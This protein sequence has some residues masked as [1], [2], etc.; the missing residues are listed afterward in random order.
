MQAIKHNCYNL[1]L[2]LLSAGAVACDQIDLGKLIASTSLPSNPELFQQLLE[3]GISPNGIS[4]SGTSNDTTTPLDAV[5]RLI[6]YPTERKVPLICTL[7]E[8]GANLEYISTPTQE[9]TTIIH[10]L[11]EIAL[12]T[13]KY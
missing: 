6:R 4:P 3:A 10:K 13:G 12:E 9:G 2:K 11:T 1:A 7:V 5:L 8:K